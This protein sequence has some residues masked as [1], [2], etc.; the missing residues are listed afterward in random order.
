MAKL[1]R[2]RRGSLQYWPRK[3][4]RKIL[5]SVN[6]E[7]IIKKNKK[8]GLLGFIGYKVG[9][10]SAFVRDNTSDSMTKNK[11]I[12]IPVTII[13][14]PQLKI[15]SVRFYKNN[16][17]A[18]EIL[19]NKLDKE[20]KR[21][22]VTKVGLR[23]L[24]TFLILMGLFLISLGFYFLYQSWQTWEA[25]PTIYGEPLQKQYNYNFLDYIT[26]R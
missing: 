4:A 12:I 20:L 11:K 6:W 25:N 8:T 26:A 22:F 7:G 5:P 16:S 13:E 2:P 9:M 18:T 15:F 10:T 17:L 1:S 14:C 23:T 3:R 21:K 24:Q 19:S